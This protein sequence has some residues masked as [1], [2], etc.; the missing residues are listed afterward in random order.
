MAPGRFVGP[1]GKGSIACVYIYVGKDADLP[2]V[3]KDIRNQG[4]TIVLMN[5]ENSKVGDSMA[6]LMSKPGIDRKPLG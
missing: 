3:A 4:A 1:I 2:A 6:K 5:C